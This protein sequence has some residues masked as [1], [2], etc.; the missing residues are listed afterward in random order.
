MSKKFKVLIEL[1]DLVL[2]PRKDDRTG[3]VVSTGSVKIDD[4]I[5][6]AAKR[7]DIS[8]ELMKAVYDLLKGV[9]LDE[10]RSLK[11]VEFG[12]THNRL[13]CDG[14]FIGDHPAWDPNVNS[15]YLVSTATAEVREAVKD[16]ELEILGM[17]SSGTYINTLTDAVSGKVNTCIT[18][19]G[20]VNLSGVRVKIAGEAE[21][22]GLHLTEINTGAVTDIPKTSVLIND[23]SSLTFI[24]P[25]DLPAGDYK[26]SLTSQFAHGAMLKEPRTYTF[27]YVLICN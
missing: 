24:V 11:H 15:L 7:S 13:G 12:L 4:L 2:T 16:A 6:I 20:G 23:P 5:A 10:I 1:Y 3:R 18:Q 9:A 17:A 22:V 19:G 14:I 8:P 26:L 21:G 27:D 25:A